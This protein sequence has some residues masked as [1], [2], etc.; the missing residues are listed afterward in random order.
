MRRPIS[1]RGATP[2][3]TD[4]KEEALLQRQVPGDTAA[5]QRLECKWVDACF[6]IRLHTRWPSGFTPQ[7][8]A[9]CLR[10]WVERTA[11]HRN[12]KDA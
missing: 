1:P 7:G 2:D 11:E 9:L 4:R 10:D 5:R 3:P 8:I 12:F 6:S